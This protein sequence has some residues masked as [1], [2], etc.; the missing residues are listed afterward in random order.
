MDRFDIAVICAENDEN[1]VRPRLSSPECLFVLDIR[2]TT[3]PE[4]QS[5]ERS[6]PPGGEQLLLH[7]FCRL[8][9]PGVVGVCGRG[10]PPAP[11]MAGGQI[12]AYGLPANGFSERRDPCSGG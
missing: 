9:Y 3:S 1:D 4:P 2:L 12:A 6:A 11:G 8:C 10:G 5:Q 7:P